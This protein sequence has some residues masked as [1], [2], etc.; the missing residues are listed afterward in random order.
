MFWQLLTAISVITFS[1]SVLLRRLLLHNDKSDPFA[2]VVV[3]QGLVGIITG[4]YAL[5]NGFEMP[6][7]SKYWFA[8]VVTIL[9]YA[10][11]HIVSTGAFQLVEASVF[12]V[13]FATSAI[14]TMIAGLF[15][16]SDRLTFT[17]LIGVALVFVSVMILV[18]LK[19]KWKLDKGVWLDY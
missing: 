11:A 8:I 4:I 3:F 15:L 7:L 10:T 14:W 17:Q 19:S 12:S 1:I 13:L 5:F 9:L 18:E 2:Y 16:F 6:D